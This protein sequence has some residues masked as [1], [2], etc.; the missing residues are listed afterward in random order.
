MG[1]SRLTGYAIPPTI[2]PFKVGKMVRLS[3]LP[4]VSSVS[5]H[6][7]GDWEEEYELLHVQ[8]FLIRCY[9]AAIRGVIIISITL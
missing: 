8:N 2:D 5:S 4:T 3:H 7:V 1:G 6:Q 9:W